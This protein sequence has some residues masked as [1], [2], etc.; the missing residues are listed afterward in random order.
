MMKSGA[1]VEVSEQM[2]QKQQQGSICLFGKNMAVA[3]TLMQE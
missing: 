3:Q 1:L 2:Y